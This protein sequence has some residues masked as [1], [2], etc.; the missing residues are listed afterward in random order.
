MDI[1][2]TLIEILQKY[3]FARAPETEVSNHLFLKHKKVI[4]SLKCAVH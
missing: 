3:K 4:K 1:K 2:M